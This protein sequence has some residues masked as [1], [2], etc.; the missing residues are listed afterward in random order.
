MKELNFVFVNGRMVY[1][2][3]NNEE[4]I[5]FAKTYRK[6]TVCEINIYKI[7][8]EHIFSVI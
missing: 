3:E 7:S 6:S 1:V 4:A 2:S 5:K 8:A